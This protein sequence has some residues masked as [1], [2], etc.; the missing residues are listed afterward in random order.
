MSHFGKL[1]DVV[2]AKKLIKKFKKICCHLIVLISGFQS[3]L[4]GICTFDISL[5][6]REKRGIYN[7]LVAFQM[8]HSG[9][10]VSACL[11]EYDSYF[12]YLLDELKVDFQISS[13]YHFSNM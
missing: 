2:F 10:L 7:N 11:V 6:I 12:M 8:R 13:R 9:E 5:K 4:L 1:P 3:E